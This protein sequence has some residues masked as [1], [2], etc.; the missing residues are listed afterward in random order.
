MDY[1]LE[2]LMDEPPVIAVKWAAGAG[3]PDGDHGKSYGC[4]A[5]F[6]VNMQLK[7]FLQVLHENKMMELRKLKPISELDGK[8]PP[9]IPALP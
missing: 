9:S 8:P 7:S 6:N 3:T 2:L 4:N 5:C 1:S